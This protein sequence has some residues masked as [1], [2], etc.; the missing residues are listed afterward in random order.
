MRQFIKNDRPIWQTNTNMVQVNCYNCGSRES[1]FYAYENG[2][3]LVKCSSCGLLYVT[4]RPS[5]RE[6]NE[7]HQT[8]LHQGETQLH[9]SGTFNK[10]KAKSYLKILEDLFQQ[11]LKKGKYVWLDIGCGNGEFISALQEF[12]EGHIIA[13]GLEPNRRK[14][15]T[16]R[17]RGL[18]VSWFD[19]GGYN[20]FY[21][22][23]SLLNVYSHLANPI[24]FLMQYKRMLKRGG[25]FLIQ[26]GDTAN[27][28]AEMHPRPFFLPDHLSF[29]SEE[30]VSS[31]LKRSGFEI[32][33]I[34]KYPAYSF[35]AV[36]IAKELVKLLWPGKKSELS[37]LP[38][39]F[40]LS[41]KLRTDMYILA[42]VPA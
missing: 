24:D 7:A 18:D 3:T 19:L 28:C 39:Q 29:A 16:A 2:F 42:S 21:D 31:I 9:T 14:Q 4:P 25:K 38:G 32:I 20:H 15:K 34:R 27:L 11:E 33:A 17:A 8:G 26:T 10:T 23:V 12:S 41:R 40:K 1:H 35:G 36:R 13:K 30:I 37:C 5:E 22:Y 6:I